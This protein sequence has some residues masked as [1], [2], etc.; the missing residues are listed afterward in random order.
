MKID[1][2]NTDGERDKDEAMKV[3]EVQ[4]GTNKSGIA[5]GN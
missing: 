2:S 1:E 3:V 5:R 4:K